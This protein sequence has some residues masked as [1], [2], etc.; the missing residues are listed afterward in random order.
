MDYTLFK[1][2]VDAMTAWVAH[3]P[4][5]IEWIR[6]KLLGDAAAMEIDAQRGR[7]TNTFLKP[8]MKTLPDDATQEKKLAFYT[9]HGA[10]IKA[11]VAATLP[12]DRANALGYMKIV[13]EDPNCPPGFPW[14]HDSDQAIFGVVEFA[15]KKAQ[16]SITTAYVKVLY[17]LDAAN[18]PFGAFVREG[19]Q[20]A[21]PTWI[22][23]KKVLAIEY[24][25]C[26]F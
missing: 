9:E 21:V 1:D 25:S 26:G 8:L 14:F 18:D 12:L 20:P 5:G 7:V 13:R 16:C 4:I 24:P 3:D 6:C 19:I 23:E 11:V 2:D 10:T 22:K 17:V 15:G